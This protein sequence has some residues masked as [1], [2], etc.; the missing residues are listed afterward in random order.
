MLFLMEVATRRVHILGATTHPTGEW[1]A[2]QARNLVIDLGER[3]G[4]FRFLI[5]DRDTKYTYAIDT[6]F[7]SEN[8]EIVR[9]PPQAPR[10]NAFAERWVRTVRRECLDRML[11]YGQR[12]LLAILGEYTAHYNEHRPHQGRQQRPPNLDALPAPVADLAARRG[13]AGIKIANGWISGLCCIE[14]RQDRGR[15]EQ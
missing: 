13:S 8:V 1:V 2:Q 15:L 3:I 12:H 6:V 5:R 14:R 4:L 7:T 9:T 11:I 10:A